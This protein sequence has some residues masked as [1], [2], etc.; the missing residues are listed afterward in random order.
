MRT[1]EEI[2]K[3]NKDLIE[4][5]NSL[6]VSKF[7]SII[8]ELN[9]LLQKN[10]DQLLYLEEQNIEAKIKTAKECFKAINEMFDFGPFSRN[11]KKDRKCTFSNDFVFGACAPR[12]INDH[13]TPDLSRCNII[14]GVCEEKQLP[15]PYEKVE[16]YEMSDDIPE[17][18]ERLDRD[19]KN[20]NKDGYKLISIEIEYK[21][22]F[23]PCVVKIK[24][25]TY[26]KHECN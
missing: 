25:A 15:K 6:D 2:R 21:D 8:K 14:F 23:G 12:I 22:S 26:I 3:E 16:Y 20:T 18:W 7:P 10:L 17:L 13:C 5:R 9:N 1:I 4:L 24:K 19:K 11:K